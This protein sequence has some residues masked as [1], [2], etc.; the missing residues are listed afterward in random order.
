MLDLIQEKDSLDPKLESLTASIAVEDSALVSIS[1]V[2]DDRL[3]AVRAQEAALA[4]ATQ[5]YEELK[6]E[7]D[8]VVAPAEAEL[9]GKRSNYE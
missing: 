7:Y 9:K 2:C 1:G 6:A 3:S 8:G 5:R 4:A